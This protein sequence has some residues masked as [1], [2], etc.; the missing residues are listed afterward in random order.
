MFR[1][2]ATPRSEVHFK[3]AK[4]RNN[5]PRKR[6]GA[7]TH[8]LVWREIGKVP[9]PPKQ[10]EPLRFSTAQ[11]ACVMCNLEQLSRAMLAYSP[12]DVISAA[13]HYC[14]AT[15][16]RDF[17]HRCKDGRVPSSR[18]GH[19]VGAEKGV[20]CGANH[21]QAL[22]TKNNHTSALGFMHA[23]GGATDA[24]LSFF[25]PCQ[26]GQRVIL[27]PTTNGVLV[28]GLGDEA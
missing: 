18:L 4:I 28:L 6:P 27:V 26:E 16:H 13:C 19:T 9:P 25:A 24:L 11:Q 1:R 21:K 22:S 3:I 23:C 14:H 10:V 7:I 8:V 15:P 5:L 17:E 2:G 20:R 12:A